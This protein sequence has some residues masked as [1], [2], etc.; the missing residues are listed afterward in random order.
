MGV[1]VLRRALSLV[2]S[3]LAALVVFGVAGF[4][5]LLLLGLIGGMR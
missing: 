4:A 5:G 1:P 3:L 2:S